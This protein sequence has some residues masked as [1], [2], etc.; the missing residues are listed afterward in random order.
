VGDV[1]RLVGRTS[2]NGDTAPSVGRCGGRT[3][4][5][6]MTPVRP[7][8]QDGSAA[9]LALYPRGLTDLFHPN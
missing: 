7:V 9:F 6:H 5:K 8:Y 3:W 4:G 1:R 2:R